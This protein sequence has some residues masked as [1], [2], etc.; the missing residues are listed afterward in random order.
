[1]N[2]GN[3]RP[4]WLHARDYGVVV[5]NPFPRQPK[6]RREPYVRTWIKRGTPFQLSYAILIHETAP[7][8]TFDRNAAAAMLLKSFGSAK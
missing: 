1:R 3:P 6:E 7:E 8:T 2:P 5:T 4:S